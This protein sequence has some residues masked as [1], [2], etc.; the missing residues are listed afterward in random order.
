MNED[1][2]FACRYFTIKE[3]KNDDDQNLGYKPTTN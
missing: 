2:F 3:E 1:S